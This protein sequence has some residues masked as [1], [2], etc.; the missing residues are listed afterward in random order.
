M[1]TKVYDPFAVE[2]EP[3]DLDGDPLDLV[4]EADESGVRMGDLYPRRGQPP[5]SWII[6]GP[7]GSGK[8]ALAV[9]LARIELETMARFRRPWKVWSNIRIAFAE[10]CDPKIVHVI[11]R[12]T[13]DVQDLTLVLDESPSELPS[14]RWSSKDNQRFRRFHEQIRKRNVHLLGTAISAQEVD[15]GYMRLIDLFIRVK[16]YG[17][18]IA[19]FVHDHFGK[20]TGD[21][22]RKAWPPQPGDEDWRR[23]FHP[24]P[25]IVEGMY[26]S[27]QIVAPVQAEDRD[28]MIAQNPHWQPAEDWDKLPDD[29]LEGIVER[30]A[31]EN[32]RRSEQGHELLA[33]LETAGEFRVSEYYNDAGGLFDGVSSPKAWQEMLKRSGFELFRPADNKPWMGRFSGE[34]NDYGAGSWDAG[35]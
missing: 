29:E 10:L 4:D 19:V 1:T 27:F 3:F 20:I 26:D 35:P 9:G 5:Y 24:H 34:P 16:A 2:G 18:R 7:Y 31:S 33:A 17:R 25:W 13:P 14:G 15:A 30:Q 28:A 12:Y 22:N 32:R 6:L 21:A 8:T 23:W 11:E